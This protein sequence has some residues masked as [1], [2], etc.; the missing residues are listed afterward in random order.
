MNLEPD[1]QG[2]SPDILAIAARRQRD[3]YVIKVYGELDLSGVTRMSEAFAA[4]LDSDARAI[5]LD[6]RELEFLD[7][8]GVHAILMAER[9]AKERDRGFVIV[10]G[11]RQVQR[12]FEI[13]GIAERLVFS[14]G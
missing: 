8:T 10:R 4:A 11:P 9:S 14:D 6:L 3:E 13:S 1:H 5:V 7:S 12:I 2:A